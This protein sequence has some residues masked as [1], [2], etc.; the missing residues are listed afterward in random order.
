MDL[1]EGEGSGVVTTTSNIAPNSSSKSDNDN[2]HPDS[3][4]NDVGRRVALLKKRLR[5]DY[6]KCAKNEID[7]MFLE[8]I[9]YQRYDTRI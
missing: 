1:L 2:R 9:F 5:R 4:K 7:I 6:R 3:P 8:I